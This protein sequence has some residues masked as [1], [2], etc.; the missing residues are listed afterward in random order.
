MSEKSKMCFPQ[1]PRA[2]KSRNR[3]FDDFP[4]VEKVLPAAAPCTK[5]SK[6]G[7]PLKPLLLHTIFDYLLQQVA[8]I[9]SAL[10]S[11]GILFS[12]HVE[13]HGN[14]SPG[15]VCHWRGQFGV[16]VPLRSGGQKRR[17]IL[18]C[19]SQRGEDFLFGFDF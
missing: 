4:K 8:N 11:F 7:F 13:I 10:L 2:P 17:A 19:L 16:A 1:L 6:T 9:T 14:F 15:H 3:L 5:K 12:F 18:P